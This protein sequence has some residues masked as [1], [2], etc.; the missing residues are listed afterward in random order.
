MKKKEARLT[1]GREREGGELLEE[2]GVDLSQVGAERGLALSVFSLLL[3]VLNQ[4]QGEVLVEKHEDAPEEL[5]VSPEAALPLVG[6]VL[7]EVGHCQRH[8][9]DLLDAELLP[10][11][12]LEV[13]DLGGLQ[14]LLLFPQD[15]LEEAEGD[16]VQLGEVEEL[17]Q[18]G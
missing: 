2:H 17:K 4:T 13:W 16:G 7:H 3:A 11:R 1:S 9:P 8:R 6:D 12:G 10:E 5:S 14:D 18:G 15:L